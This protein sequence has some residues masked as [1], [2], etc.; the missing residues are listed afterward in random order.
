MF[1]S[2]YINALSKQTVDTSCK[3]V[4]ENTWGSY[5]SA[6]TTVKDTSTVFQYTL[7]DIALIENDNILYAITDD[8]KSR[9]ELHG[10]LNTC[11]MKR[12]LKI[13]A[14]NIN[15]E[16]VILDQEDDDYISEEDMNCC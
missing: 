16:E 13:F 12:L 3:S 7:K 2:S 14:R 4:T 8:L 1:N 11:D 9:Y 6:T 15:V 10:F 5:E